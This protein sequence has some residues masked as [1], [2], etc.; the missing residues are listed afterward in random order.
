ML[1]F[2]LSVLTFNLKNKTMLSLAQPTC[3]GEAEALSPA[4]WASGKGVLLHIFLQDKWGQFKVREKT[5][6]A[7][8]DAKEQQNHFP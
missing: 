2:L 6:Y 1:I 3:H 8:R 7:I 4:G 5:G